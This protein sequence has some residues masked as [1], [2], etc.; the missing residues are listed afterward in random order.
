M[1]HLHRQIAIDAARPI[2]RCVH[3]RARDR[4]V[5]VHQVFAFAEAVQEHRHRTDVETVRA[6]PHQV[7]EDARYLVEHDADVLRPLWRCNTEQLLDREHIAVLVAHHGYIVEPV[8][9]TNRLVVGLRLGQ[10]LGRAVQQPDMRIGF[11]NGLAVH[12]E[13]QPQI[14]REP[15]GAAARSS[16]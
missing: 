3:T 16:L 1:R 10:F 13:D 7:V 4:L 5:A 9:I 2:V 14:R 15:Q 12:F 6:E 8:H 11:L